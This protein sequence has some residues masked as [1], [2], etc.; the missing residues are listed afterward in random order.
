MS[1]QKRSKRQPADKMRILLAGMD[2]AVNISELCRQE[3]IA[4]TQ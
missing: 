4:V 2:T 1:E 3:G